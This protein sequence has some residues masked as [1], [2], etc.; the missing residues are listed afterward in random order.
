MFLKKL[1]KKFVIRLGISIHNVNIDIANATLPIF[2]NTPKNL[3]IELPRRLINPEYMF[4]GNNISLGPGTFLLALTHYPTISMRQSQEHQT[5]QNFSPK[6]SI[7]N[8]VTSTANLQ[9]AAA[10]E[11]T[12]E[13]DVMFAS[14]IHINDASHGYETA[15]EPY[16]C[17]SL[18][19]I[20]PILIKR[21][22]WIG[23]NVIVL[24]GVTIGEFT[25][26]GANSIVTKSLPD[27]CIAVG[28]SA[29]VIKKWD[30]TTHKWFAV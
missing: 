25:I 7:G 14:N 22:C 28:T 23:Q 17:Q 3:N 4:F 2:G 16:K 19:G 8:R 18:S 15:N 12:I 27:R 13:D 21:G 6:I 26:V 29:K 11:V 30:E 1:I 10:K 20:D 5:T 24:P 9:I